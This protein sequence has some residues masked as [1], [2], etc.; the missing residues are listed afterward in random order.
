MS[1]KSSNIFTGL[2]LTGI[3]LIY[4]SLHLFPIVKS[5][6]Y[7]PNEK[8]IIPVWL[9]F[10]VLFKY[11][12]L[13]N[14]EFY[15]LLIF[16][17]VH[18]LY[19]AINNYYLLDP[20]TSETQA[21]IFLALFFC[22]S[23]FLFLKTENN[24]RFNTLMFWI[25]TISIVVTGGATIIATL[26]NPLAVRS[27]IGTQDYE[28]VRALLSQ[29]V[30]GY[31]FQYMV[32]LISPLFCYAVK[33]TKNLMWYVP[34]LIGTLSVL[35]S[36]VFGIIIVHIL[37]AFSVYF[38]LNTKNLKK[39]LSRIALLAIILSYSKKAIALLLIWIA[40]ILNSFEQTHMKLLELGNSIMDDG[41]IDTNTGYTEIY[42]SRFETSLNAFYDSPILG[43]NPSGGHHFWI[44]NLAEHGLIGTLPWLLV[45]IV[46]YKYISTVC[47]KLETLLILNTIIMFVIIG[48]TKNILIQSMPMY[49]FFIAPIVILYFRN[50]K[51]KK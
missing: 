24:E 15:I 43:G 2:V 16:L 14:K 29:N 32:A 44:D 30:G 37:N 17:F 47:N 21:D 50:K 19:L 48:L 1:S 45:L 9:F 27:M 49:L 51:I 40:E 8:L 26:K 34:F 39:Y 20:R 13:F 42:A 38:I 18:V 35:F 31:S 28:N 33:Q 25:F 36:Q 22:I 4:F 10:L 7:V 5:L 6:Q 23:F 41:M 12:V 46:F 3:A 11:K